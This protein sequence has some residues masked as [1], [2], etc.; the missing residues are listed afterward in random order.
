MDRYN[1]GDEDQN[2]LIYLIQ[3]Y[4]EPDDDSDQTAGKSPNS[5]K[6]LAIQILLKDRPTNSDSEDEE[7][8][9]Y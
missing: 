1:Y 6:R 2:D 8:P 7:L 3:S 5:K 4:R 9:F